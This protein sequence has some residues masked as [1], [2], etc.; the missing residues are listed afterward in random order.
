VIYLDSSAL[1]KLLFE[2]PESKALAEWLADAGEETMVCSDLAEIEVG[3]ACRRID[4]EALARAKRLLDGLDLAS[5]TRE[6]V[7]RA[8]SVGPPP[9]RSLDAIHLATALMLGD[10]V[11]SF[12]A[13]DRRLRDAAL[14]E[15]LAVV[16]PGLRA[17]EV[18]GPKTA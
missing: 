1:L 11:S 15:Q 9:L 10:S 4:P 5:I 12:V 18:D 3:R 13:Y 8:A 17:E 7:E 16:A 14:D 6:V 2:E